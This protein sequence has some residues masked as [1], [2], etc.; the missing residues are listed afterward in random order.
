MLRTLRPGGTFFSDIVPQKFSFVRMAWYLRGNYKQVHD[1]YPYT[2]EEIRG[3]LEQCG[4][5][6]IRVFPHALSLR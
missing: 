5:D 4:L 2:A 1:E 3:W 6:D